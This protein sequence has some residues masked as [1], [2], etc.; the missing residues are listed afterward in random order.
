M[1][2]LHRAEAGCGSNERIIRSVRALLHSACLENRLTGFEL[3]D[4]R[5]GGLARCKDND[6][7]VQGR[8]VLSLI[9]RRRKRSTLIIARV[10]SE[11]RAP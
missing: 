6:N 4:G 2:R 1:K 8:P 11:S 7:T 5:Q 3:P 10:T 9:L